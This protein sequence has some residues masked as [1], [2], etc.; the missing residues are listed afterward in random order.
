MGI[1][2]LSKD[3]ILVTLPKDAQLGCELSS[4]NE[5]ACSDQGHH[6]IIDFSQIEIITSES[7]NSLILLD[8]LLTDKGY[9]LILCAVPAQLK[10]VFWRT[11]LESL[12]QFAPDEMSALQ[13]VRHDLY[14]YG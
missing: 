6:V 7:L 11:G 5:I 12:F 10:Q 1:H 3:I 2:I 8:R 14:L 9:K 4:I 13:F